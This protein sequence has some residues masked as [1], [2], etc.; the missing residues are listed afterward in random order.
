MK[1]I[2]IPADQRSKERLLM[3]AILNAT[4]RDKSSTST[5]SYL[6][7]LIESRDH[8]RTD[9]PLSGDISD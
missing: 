2:W 3:K 9:T 1:G 6:K 4:V 8:I 7:D 5:L